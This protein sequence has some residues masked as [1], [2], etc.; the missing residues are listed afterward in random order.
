MMPPRPVVLQTTLDA[1]PWI[2]GKR[3]PCAISKANVQGAGGA[4][5]LIGELFAT[6]FH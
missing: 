4:E 2:T 3:K 6:S 1:Q 5:Y